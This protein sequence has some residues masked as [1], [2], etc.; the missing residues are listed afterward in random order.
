[1]S[2][3]FDVYGQPDISDSMLDPEHDLSDINEMFPTPD[4]VA[5]TVEAVEDEAVAVEPQNTGRLPIEKPGTDADQNEWMKVF[6]PSLLLAGFPKQIPSSEM[7]TPTSACLR[8]SHKVTPAVPTPIPALNLNP[9][10]QPLQVRFEQSSFSAPN[11]G[12][13]SISPPLT[14]STLQYPFQTLDLYGPSFSHPSFEQPPPLTSSFPGMEYLNFP[15]TPGPPRSARRE[16]PEVDGMTEIMA[17]ASSGGGSSMDMVAEPK[18]GPVQVDAWD[19][20]RTPMLVGG[21]GE[22]DRSELQA[23]LLKR[24]RGRESVRVVSERTQL[25]CRPPLHL[26]HRPPTSLFF[27]S[28]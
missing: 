15:D 13:H 6:V 5:M 24:K 3:I 18:M 4:C 11:H 12:S 21:A 26:H 2:A 1:M 16:A 20:F 9:S 17:I 23:G 8:S 27:R 14:L 25:T 10:S 7:N 19:I 22:V 28:V